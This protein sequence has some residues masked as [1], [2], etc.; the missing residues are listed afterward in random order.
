MLDPKVILPKATEISDKTRKHL[1]NCL[2]ES[3]SLRR[4]ID[5][6][7]KE[8]DRVMLAYRTGVL[9]PTQLGDELQKL[10]NR[11]ISLETRLRDIE[12]GDSSKN[13]QQSPDEFCKVASSR[14]KSFTPE[15]R[16]RFLNL[17]LERI[18]LNNDS[19]R[20]VGIIPVLSTSESYGS[21]SHPLS[22]QADSATSNA[23]TKSNS[24][25]FPKTQ[26]SETNKDV[27]DSTSRYQSGISKPHEYAFFSNGPRGDGM[28]FE[29]LRTVP[30][31]R[32]QKKISTVS[33]QPLT[34]SVSMLV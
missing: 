33:D 18:I 21:V 10:K 14:M 19:V 2:N 31:L 20:I 11:K 23:T 7:Q 34:R 1:Q 28:Q 27:I 25:D 8:E 6:L 32:V 5:Q 17:I 22:L 9:T 29:L 30:R 15:E 12:T 16:Q 3:Q 24:I 13:Q 4:S 26:L